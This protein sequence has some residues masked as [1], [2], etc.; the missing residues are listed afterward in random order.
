MHILLVEDDPKTA[1]YVTEGLLK[2]GHEVC[3]AAT[4]TDGLSQARNGDHGLIIVDRMLPVLDGLSL[5]KLLRAEGF[6]G[7]TLFLTTMSDLDDRVEG[8]EAGADDYLT[9]PFALPELLARVNALLRRS[10]R[11]GQGGAQ[12]RLCVGD[13]EVDLLARTVVRDGRRIDL[14]QQE[15]L[16]LQYLMENAGRVVTRTML[17]EHV[18]NL[19]FDPRSNI[20]ELHISQLRSKIGRA[21]ASE[22]IQTVRGAGY[23]IRA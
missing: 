16:L 12:T 17:L 7:A 22:M 10:H 5:V 18:W 20:V 21:C 19:D 15:F 14:Q 8:L 4:G 23:T 9:K 2:H 1:L 6:D 11:L 3:W 13:L